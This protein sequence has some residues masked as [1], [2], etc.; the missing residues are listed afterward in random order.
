ME[1]S[2]RQK[3]ENMHQ[4]LLEVSAVVASTKELSEV[5]SK[6]HQQFVH[7][8]DTLLYQNLQ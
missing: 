5:F 7:R 3:A 1:I 2:E 4:V 8:Q 6:V